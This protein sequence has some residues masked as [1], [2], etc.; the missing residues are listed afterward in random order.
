M[1]GRPVVALAVAVALAA[2][3]AAPARARPSRRS[4]SLARATTIE[5]RLGWASVSC[6]YDYTV[7]LAR[8]G[9]A[10]V[11]AP[12]LAVVNAAPASV[13]ATVTVP[14]A[15]I[16]R[17]ERVAITARRRRAGVTAA[18]D[19]PAP[20]TDAYPEASLRFVMPGGEDRIGVDALGGPLTWVHAGVPA[21]LTDAGPTDDRDAEVADA[22]VAD[23]F[24]AVVAA[25]GGRGLRERVCHGR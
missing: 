15:L 24:A 22:E 1:G 5:V 23:A 19:S 7:R 17:P 2:V 25:A 13:P 4:A 21:R 10:Y 3:A 18:P 11:G 12:Q 20:P 14:R 6:T 8:R 16:V 9:R